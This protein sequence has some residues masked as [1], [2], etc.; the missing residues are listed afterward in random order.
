MCVLKK[1]SLH[2]VRKS[3]YLRV[4][5]GCRYPTSECNKHLNK[6]IEKPS[7][8][9]GSLSLLRGGDGFQSGAEDVQRS[10]RR[11]ELLVVGACHLNYY[12]Y[13]HGH[14]SLPPPQIQGAFG[15]LETLGDELNHLEIG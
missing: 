6:W 8:L 10:G 1:K 4:S 5:T 11:W 7:Q 2:W 14:P 3:K 15:K 12:L 9:I 13:I